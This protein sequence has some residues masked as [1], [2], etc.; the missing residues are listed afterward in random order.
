MCVRVCV[1]VCVCVCVLCVQVIKRIPLEGMRVEMV[2]DPDMRHGFQII[3]TCKSF[4]LEARY[5]QPEPHFLVYLLT[6]LQNPERATYNVLLAQYL[7]YHI[8][9]MQTFST[10]TRF[11]I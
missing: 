6:K 5:I 3:S 2:N 1:C 7:W 8:Y 10:F 9:S 11:H 4:R